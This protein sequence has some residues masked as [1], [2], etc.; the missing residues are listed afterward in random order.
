MLP[1]LIHSY[2]KAPFSSI[3][4]SACK[5]YIIG[6]MFIMAPP[7]RKLTFPA[8]AQEFPGMSI[9][10][11]HSLAS[12][13]RQP[14]KQGLDVV[15]LCLRPRQHFALSWTNQFRNAPKSLLCPSARKLQFF[16][17]S[18]SPSL[19]R[20]SLN[21]YLGDQALSECRADPSSRRNLFLD[22]SRLALYF[23]SCLQHGTKSSKALEGSSYLRFLKTYI[24]IK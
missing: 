10:V 4:L 24:C 21:T 19:S 5:A 14:R 13:P 12:L 2:P 15:G 1:T 22:R 6:H 11:K 3:A 17:H 18:N 23:Y 8:T 20:A 16:S 9:F 7:A